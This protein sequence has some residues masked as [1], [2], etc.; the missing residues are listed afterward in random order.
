MFIGK[1]NLIYLALFI[2]IC[3]IIFFVYVTFWRNHEKKLKE[4]FRTSVDLI[5][6][7]P[8]EIKIQIIKKITEVEE[9]EEK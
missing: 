6:L 7:I 2:S 9:K 8:E 5:N 3:V 1:Q 4:E